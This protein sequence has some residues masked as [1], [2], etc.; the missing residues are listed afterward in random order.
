MARHL[1]PT[2]QGMSYKPTVPEVMPWVVALYSLHSAGCC[3]HIVL[4]DG[5]CDSDSVRWVIRHAKHHECMQF[6]KALLR[7]SP[8]QRHKLYARTG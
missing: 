3:L 5:N 2:E 7:M 8:T 1:Q 4:D 6:A